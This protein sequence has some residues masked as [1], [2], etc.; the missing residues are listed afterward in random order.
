MERVA[1]FKS[2]AAQAELGELVFPTSLDAAMKIRQ[3]LRDP[4][5]HIEEVTKLVVTEPLLSARVVAM[6][7]AIAYNRSGREITD[8]RSA[9][10]RVGFRTLN[11]LATAVI[12][13]QFAGVI[14]DDD[15]RAKSDQLW[16]HT[17]HVSALAHLIARRIT[18]FDP[19]TAMFAAIVHEVGG[20]YLLS[21][22][23]AYPGLLDGDPAAWVE[24]GEKQIG[25]VVLK[26]LQVPDEVSEAIEVL[27]NGY[28]SLPPVSLG[29]TLLLA[30]NL[31]PVESPLHELPGSKS[32]K[33][34]AIL[35]YVNGDETL[36]GIIKDS[37]EEVASLSR[38]L[39]F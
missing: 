6:A 20:F 8:V 10:A 1:A 28:L 29:D 30:N 27:W 34:A 5:C 36:T 26:R 13:R 21:R 16:L 22:A 39:Q 3:S 37:A 24:H 23:Q 33:S 4:D 31:A 17:T 12:A 7:N 25:R 32:Q 15:L 38:A 35:D 2:I 9:V 18:H 11:T 14:V 19:E